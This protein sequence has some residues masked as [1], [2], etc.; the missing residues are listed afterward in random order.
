MVCYESEDQRASSRNEECGKCGV[1]TRFGLGETVAVFLRETL[2][3]PIGG[4]VG[5]EL[6]WCVSTLL[7]PICEEE[8]NM[9][10][11]KERANETAH[12]DQS[13]ALTPEIG[14]RGN[15]LSSNQAYSNDQS[16]E[17]SVP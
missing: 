12:V 9:Y 15:K 6:E 16:H 7:L 17:S 8:G 14:R 11:S 13:N 10:S 3:R 1:E 2:G 4:Q 5:V